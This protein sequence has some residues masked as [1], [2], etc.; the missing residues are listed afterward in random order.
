LTREQL[1]GALKAEG[2]GAEVGF[3]SLHAGRSRSR[4]RAH[5][6]LIHSKEQSPQR[7]VLH[8]PVL[9][10]QDGPQKVAAALHRMAA[11]AR[12]IAELT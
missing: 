5:D 4:Y 12:R 7:I 10:Q 2:I 11:H 9:L 6:E 1:V 8:H 3:R